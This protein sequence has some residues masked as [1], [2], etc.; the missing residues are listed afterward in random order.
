MPGIIRASDR[1]SS[2]GV[3]L[4]GS[5]ARFFMKR[6]VARVGDPVSCP[7]HGN[8]RIAQA[9]SKAFDNGVEVAQHGDLCECGCYLISSLPN[10]GRR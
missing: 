9:T 1:N 6:A 3:V 10:S 7:K 8:N 2:G 4:N 5:S